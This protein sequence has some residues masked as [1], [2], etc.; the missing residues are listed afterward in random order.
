MK[1]WESNEK[2]FLLISVVFFSMGMVYQFISIENEINKNFIVYLHFLIPDCL[3]LLSIIF[4][5]I[6]FDCK[7]EGREFSQ[8]ERFLLSEL[9][10][11][12]D[13]KDIIGFMLKNNEEITEYF[14]ISKGQEK[15]SYYVSI[16]C[17]VAGFVMLVIAIIE[18]FFRTNMEIT[19]ITIIGATLTEVISGLVLWIHSK[20]ASQ[21]NHYY[22]ALHEN[23]KFLSAINIAEKMEGDG[24]QKAYS[25]I[26]MAQIGTYGNNAKQ[27][28]GDAEY[29]FG[30][31]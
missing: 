20:S 19:T 7:S 30:G 24:K 10:S 13:K 21:L 14:K 16:I 1:K 4:I 9:E 28:T 6:Y 22:N 31:E 17:S 29:N 27:M 8:Y 5:K 15:I 25:E 18:F 12:S 23:E 2:I 3:F 26:I 11:N